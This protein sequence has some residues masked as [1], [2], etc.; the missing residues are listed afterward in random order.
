MTKGTHGTDHSLGLGPCYVQGVTDVLQRGWRMGLGRHRRQST[1][2]VL[3]P[4]GAGTA[5]GNS[6][7]I[8]LP[9]WEKGPSPL[10]TCA[11]FSMGRGRHSWGPPGDVPHQAPPQPCRSDPGAAASDRRREA[12]RKEPAWGAGR[13]GGTRLPLGAGTSR[14]PAPAQQRAAAAGLAQ[15]CG[16][17]S[18]LIDSCF[19]ALPHSPNPHMHF[20]C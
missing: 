15:L 10:L 17:Q 19:L 13:G 14:P 20:S 16:F 8:P 11:D 1:R 9:S 18:C 3:G 6:P 4:Y 12:T 2:C 7:Q 5:W